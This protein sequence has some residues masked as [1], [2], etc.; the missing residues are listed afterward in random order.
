MS[1]KA[2]TVEIASPAER[3]LLAGLM[4]FYIYDF[5]EL[6]PEGAAGFVFDGEGR[7]PDYL[8]L[9]N[10]WMEVDRT[11]LVI[12]AG[13][14][15][16]GFALLNRHSHVGGSPDHNMAEFFVARKYRRRGVAREAVREILARFRGRWEVAILERNT[17]ARAFWPQAIAAAPN[18]TELALHPGDGDAWDGPVWTFLAV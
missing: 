6:Q 17:G 15:V 1:D 14:E 2:I 5:S 3:P 4:Q 12:R 11:P 9:P 16:A 7:Y 10:Y 8:Q 13:D 18:V